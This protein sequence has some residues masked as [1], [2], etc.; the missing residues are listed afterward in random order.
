MGAY[1]TPVL[2]HTVVQALNIQPD[3]VYVDVTM[4]AAGHTLAI[5][6]KLGPK[7]R[8]LAF[9]Q[10]EDAVKHAP[11]DPRVTFVHANFRYLGRFLK[12][13]GIDLVDGILADLGVS[14]HQLD[15]GS[16]GFSFRFDGP[17]DMRMHQAGET[18]AADLL[19]RLPAAEI[20]DILSKGGE[21]R[22]ARTLAEAMVQARATKPFSTIGD[23]MKVADAHVKGK[24]N[25]YLAQVFQALR[26]AVNGELE[27]LDEFLKTSV[28]ALR[29]GGRLVVISYHSLEDRMVK[30][31]MRKGTPDGSFIKD[32]KGRIYRPF[33][34]IGK[35]PVL[36][37]EDEIRANPRARSA[38]L[39]VAE[40]I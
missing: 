35:S 17:L 9:D 11:N 23:L 1:H 6:S 13:Y 40:K 25:R 3:G 31:Y 16:R 4:G 29:P 27:S 7:G 32:D 30:Y 18:T 19:N 14:S 38:K 24:R 8:L 22:N 33:A 39:R 36:P 12:Y 37:D 26:M 15:E 34:E 21:V 2:L 28:A 20:Q 10:D 5:L